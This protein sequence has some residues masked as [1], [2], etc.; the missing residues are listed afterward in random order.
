MV[1]GQF[2]DKV[3]IDVFKVLLFL[4]RGNQMTTSVCVCVCVCVCVLTHYQ[5]IVILDNIQAQA[6]Q[7]RMLQLFIQE[8]EFGLQ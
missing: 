8:T 6:V 4:F 3:A 7:S 5:L 1:L 2:F